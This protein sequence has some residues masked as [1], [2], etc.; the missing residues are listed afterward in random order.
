MPPG[1][2]KVCRALRA[3]PTASMPASRR[4]DSAAMPMAPAVVACAGGWSDGAQ[5]TA[6]RAIIQPTVRPLYGLAQCP[7]SVRALWAGARRSGRGWRGSRDLARRVRGRA[8]EA[9]WTRALHDGFVADSA[10]RPVTPSPAKTAASSTA[11]RTR[12]PDQSYS[13]SIL[14][15]GR[16]FRE[17]CLA[18][19]AAQAA[20]Q[21]HLGQRD[22][23]SA[24]PSP[25]RHKSSNGDIVEVDGR[26]GRVRG[27]AWVVPGQAARDR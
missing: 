18:P 19:G 17:Y 10:A 5:S 22:S 4:R 12:A 26:Q 2:A 1:R 15:L 25:K 13:I 9:R 16:T 20:H 11:V 27:A 21:A 3:F 24:P 14:R 6:R 23:R 7:R 8:F